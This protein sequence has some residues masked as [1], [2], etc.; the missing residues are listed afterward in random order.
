VEEIAMKKPKM[1]VDLLAVPNVC[2]EAYEARARLLETRGKGTSRKKEDREFNTADRGD[3][4]TEGTA[5]TATS[6]PQ[7]KKRRVLFSVPMTQ[8]SG[9]RFTAPHGTIWKSVKLFWIGR[10]CHHQQ[11]RCHMSPDELIIVGKILTEMSRWGRS[12]LSSGAACPSPPR[13]RGRS[14]NVISA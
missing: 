6:N 1:V 5:D 9:V 14:S 13:H 11:R 10:R 8:R 3:R 4:R 7:S 2:I 12:M